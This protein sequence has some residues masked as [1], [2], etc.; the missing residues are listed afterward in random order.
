MSAKS[1]TVKMPDSV[2]KMSLRCTFT[3][4]ELLEQSKRLAEAA[5]QKYRLEEDAKRISSEYKS[6]IAN[7]A[8]DVATLSEKVTNGYEHR[9]VECRIVYDEPKAGMKAIYR[10]DTGEKVDERQMNDEERQLKLSLLS[11]AHGD[12][13]SGTTIASP[14]KT[15]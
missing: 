9:D 11:E 8:L 10:N 12:G 6:R 14:G 4:E 1:K 2:C 7:T 13:A 5:R 3:H 15:P